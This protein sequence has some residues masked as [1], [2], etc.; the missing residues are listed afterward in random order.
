LDENV[1]RKKVDCP[2]DTISP[3]RFLK[4][5]HHSFASS[6]TSQHGLYQLDFFMQRFGVQELDVM[7][8]DG[9]GLK[10]VVW[11]VDL[12]ANERDLQISAGRAIEQITVGTNAV[13]QPVY[14]FK[15][16]YLNH[17]RQG[18]A[19]ILEETQ[20]LADEGFREVVSGL[21]I[22]NV[23]S[24]EVLKEPFLPI[25]HG[26]DLF[27]KY[28]R[29]RRADLIVVNR[30]LK[31]RFGMCLMGGFAEALAL[32]S[33][34]PVLSINPTYF[35]TNVFKKILFATDF[36]DE[37]KEAY[38]VVIALA[39]SMKSEVILFHKAA[40][41]VSPR[42]EPFMRMQTGFE[43]MLKREVEE[44]DEKA[45]KWIDEAKQENVPATFVLDVQSDRTPAEA[46]LARAGQDPCLIALVGQSGPIYNF[47][48][49][50]TT[51]A[52]LKSCDT[53]VLILHSERARKVASL[54][55]RQ[56]D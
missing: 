10:T 22:S 47:L 50:S 51:R 25:R 49:G 32:S 56:L 19:R 39:R 28:A 1:G 30:A 12:L 33:E 26:A 52:V 23:S 48:L 8:T 53:P 14:L 2:D 35:D 43:K 34:I 31:R 36:S 3:A 37:S 5:E 27:L 13:V 17:E 38:S 44:S 15:I 55:Q 21:D 7:D 54:S 16:P 29:S 20:K 9:R 41:Q 18:A 42:L 4:L 45:K 24:P 6:K 46:I 40:I 11:A